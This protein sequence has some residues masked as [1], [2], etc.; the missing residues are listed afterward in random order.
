MWLLLLACTPDP[1]A[2]TDPFEGA[3][4][5]VL[6]GATSGPEEVEL[7]FLG[8]SNLADDG[9]WVLTAGDRDRVYE[10]MIVL[11]QRP[12][13]GGDYVPAQVRWRKGL[14][15]LLD[16]EASCLLAVGPSTVPGSQSPWDAELG[17]EGLHTEEGLG[18]DE[19]PW[20]LGGSLR[21]GALT[22]VGTRD[23]ALSGPFYRLSP[24]LTGTDERG[25]LDPATSL[26]VPW[27][28]GEVLVL[29]EDGEDGSRDDVVL[30]LTPTDTEIGLRRWTRAQA[31]PARGLA[32]DLSSSAE[33][34]AALEG[35]G[36]E[37][38]GTALRVPLWD[39]VTEGEDTARILLR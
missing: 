15:A 1:A 3:V 21:G 26:V 4:D 39:S 18:T 31:D 2:P 23:L 34:T 27:R 38:T 37:Q 13:E 36:E 11:D 7:T 30:S 35:S 22:E 5:L 9:L 17:C 19:A 8:W 14:Q 12:A 24:A 29:W 25:A 20:S 28:A 32:L 16:A 33:L 6:T 10:L